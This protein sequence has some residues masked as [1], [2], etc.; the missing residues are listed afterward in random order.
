MPLE[1]AYETVVVVDHET[2]TMRV[3]TTRE[4]IAGQLRRKGF[5]E[6]TKSNSKPY[7]RFTGEEGQLSFRKPKALRPA[8]GFALNPHPKPHAGM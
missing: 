2:G 1:F 7:R 3:D 4:G 8:R 5:I 6:V